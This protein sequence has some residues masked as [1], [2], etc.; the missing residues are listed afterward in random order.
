MRI[1]GQIKTLSDMVISYFIKFKRESMLTWHDGNI[2][3][4]EIWLKL[5]GD[6]GGG[7]FKLTFQMSSVTLKG[8]IPTTT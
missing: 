4:N 8:V 7:N 5:G 6:K 3:E 2:P 1:V